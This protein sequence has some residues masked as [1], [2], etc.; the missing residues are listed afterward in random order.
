MNREGGDLCRLAMPNQRDVRMP[1]TTGGSP[2]SREWRDEVPCA[3][4]VTPLI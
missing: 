4:S 2:P 1:F 3:G